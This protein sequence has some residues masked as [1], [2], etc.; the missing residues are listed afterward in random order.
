M[1]LDAE[2]KL[3]LRSVCREREKVTFGGFFPS[4]RREKEFVCVCVCICVLER[5]LGGGFVLTKPYALSRDGGKG[6]DSLGL[7]C[8]VDFLSLS[9]SFVPAVV[10]TFDFVW[11]QSLSEVAYFGG[12]GLLECWIGTVKVVF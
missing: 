8:A 7:V 9:V 6:I 12:I 5:R 10:R 1:G 2:D 11:K 3:A 4:A